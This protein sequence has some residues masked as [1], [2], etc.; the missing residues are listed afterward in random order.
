VL[1]VL[2]AAALCFA[3]PRELAGGSPLGRSL[4]AFLAVFWGLRLAI[5]LFA[6]DRALRRARPVFDALFLAG[7]AYLTGVFTAAALLG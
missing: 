6:Y 1:V 2:G 3:F 5:Q 4:S 7:F